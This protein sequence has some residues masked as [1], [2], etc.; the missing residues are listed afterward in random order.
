MDQRMSLD[1]NIQKN[2][3]FVSAWNVC[4]RLHKTD[5]IQ[6]ILLYSRAADN[7]MIISELGKYGYSYLVCGVDNRVHQC[8]H[9]SRCDHR[10]ATKMVCNA[11]HRTRTLP[12]HILQNT[13]KIAL[14]RHECQRHPNDNQVGIYGKVHKAKQTSIICIL[15]SYLFLDPYLLNISFEF[16]FMIMIMNV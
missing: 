10:S 3:M 7:L 5:S 6:S 8:H 15:F 16:Y 12:L 13:F 14:D 4:F 9:C 1:G 11:C 2:I